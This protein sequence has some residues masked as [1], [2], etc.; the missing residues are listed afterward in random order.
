M[1]TTKFAIVSSPAHNSI[2]MANIGSKHISKR[3]DFTGSDSTG[4]R[5]P[6][7]EILAAGVC[8]VCFVGSF[9]HCVI[10]A[11]KASASSLV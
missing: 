7:A 3:V 6:F 8:Q 2:I 5:K 10:D 11:R 9:V 4:V 1:P